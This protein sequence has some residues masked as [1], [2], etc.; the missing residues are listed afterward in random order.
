MSYNLKSYIFSIKPI[1]LISCSWLY[2]NGVQTWKE[3]MRRMKSD[4]FSFRLKRL[5]NSLSLWFLF[6]QSTG[7]FY[8][9]L[10]TFNVLYSVNKSNASDKLK[11]EKRF[12]EM[13]ES[14]V[15]CFS[16]KLFCFVI[17]VLFET[18]IIVIVYDFPHIQ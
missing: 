14:I 15:N 6:S 9:Q 18:C 1:D 8:V 7:L 4:F 12:M 13:T 11:F 16:L 17:L 5:L 10:N 2:Q 3:K